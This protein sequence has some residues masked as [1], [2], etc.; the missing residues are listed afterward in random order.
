VKD[1]AQSARAPGFQPAAERPHAA[2][3]VFE[4]LARA[5]L[6]GELAV[7]EKLPGERSLAARFGVSR[8]ILRQA[9]HKLAELG[10][11]KVRMGGTTIV[12]DPSQ[13][14][15]LG[16]LE[17]EYRLGPGSASDVYDYMERQV[18]Q[19]HAMLHIAERRG[20]QAQLEQL[21][22]IV[23]EWAET[24]APAGGMQAFE[25]RFWPAVAAACG[26]RLYQFETNWWFSLIARH[27]RSF[28]PVVAPAHARIAAFRELVRR[29]VARENAAALYLE[30]SS[31]VLDSMRRRK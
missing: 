21:A 29:L 23:E 9:I 25:S 4:Q 16:V 26:N 11:L 5:I 18:M 8:I 6:R 13:S 10:L 14:A 17:L 31:V 3:D 1:A 22:A 7:G 28:H 24:G 30:L 15:H 2:D 20:T 12:L 19:G 27:P